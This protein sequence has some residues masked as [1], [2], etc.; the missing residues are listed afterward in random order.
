MPPRAAAPMACADATDTPTVDPSA[1]DYNRP[2]SGRRG[3]S[4]G[5]S[6]AGTLP[7]EGG[8]GG[9]GGGGGKGKA[10]EA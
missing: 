1:M 7:S 6:D 3:S 4:G 10:R 8:R 5:F 9:D 2:H